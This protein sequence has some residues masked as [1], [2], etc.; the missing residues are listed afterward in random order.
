MPLYLYLYVWSENGLVSLKR[1]IFLHNLSH[2]L[3]PLPSPDLNFD[4][5]DI[6]KNENCFSKPA[7]SALPPPYPARA[8]ISDADT[9]PGEYF[10]DQHHGV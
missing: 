4:R 3:S 8:L 5:L 7:A 6:L 10:S 1:P 9:T 2:V